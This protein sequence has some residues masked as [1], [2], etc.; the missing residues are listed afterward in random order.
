MTALP[1]T[2]IHEINERLET[3]YRFNSVVD[4]G[5]PGFAEVPAGS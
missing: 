5:E 1:E 4:G 2:A 3:R